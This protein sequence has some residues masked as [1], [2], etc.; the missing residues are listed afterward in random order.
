[1]YGGYLTNSFSVLNFL[2]RACSCWKPQSNKVKIKKPAG[3]NDPNFSNYL[4]KL[5]N[6]LLNISDQN[7]IKVI[8]NEIQGPLFYFT[9]ENAHKCVKFIL[10]KAIFYEANHKQFNELN[11]YNLSLDLVDTQFLLKVKKNKNSIT[12]TKLLANFKNEDQEPYKIAKQIIN[13][14]SNKTIKPEFSISISKFLNTTKLNG[15]IGKYLFPK[16]YRSTNEIRKCYTTIFFDEDEPTQKNNN[17][18]RYI[19]ISNKE[20]DKLLV[21]IEKLENFTG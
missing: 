6:L 4:L 12:E 3:I 17:K 21:E 15:S 8:K 2:K 1:M 16:N 20:K 19:N 7:E 18:I 5:G 11:L 9:K 14:N 10:N 13:G